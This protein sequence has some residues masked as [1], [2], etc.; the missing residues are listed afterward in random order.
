MSEK[1]QIPHKRPPTV[2]QIAPQ[3]TRVL[4]PNPSPM[5]EAGTNTYLVGRKELAVIDPGPNDSR[6]LEELL[7]E[8]GDRPVNAI[9]VTHSHRDHSLLCPALKEKTGAPV[10]AYGGSEA[11]RSAVM[12]KLVGK[13]G[14]GEGVDTDFTPD[15]SIADGEVIEGADWAL[16]ALW[17]PGHM[18]NHLCFAMDDTVF[19]GDLV[20]GWSTSLVSPPDGDLVAFMSS[21]RVLAARTDRMF[22]PGHGGPITDPATRL[23]ELISHREARMNQIRAALIEA[24]GTPRAL[25]QRVYQDVESKLLPVAERNLLAHLIALVETNEAQ[26]DPE[27]GPQAVFS[28]R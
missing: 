11:G 8:I 26:A 28:L 22:L 2:I 14:G 6:H 20:M 21:C 23:A 16:T 15:R 5:T 4:A 1:E 7:A 19:T 25:T 18:G 13:V 10:L 9:L 12:T 27:I 24:P 17:T 3:I